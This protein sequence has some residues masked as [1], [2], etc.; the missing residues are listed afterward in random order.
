MYSFA[1]TIL[2][3]FVSPTAT[4]AENLDPF[5]QTSCLGATMSAEKA[6]EILGPNWEVNL[7]EG[8]PERIV[9]GWARYRQLMNGVKGKWYPAR[10]QP[11]PIR[12]FLYNSY[13][14]LGLKI[15]YGDFTKENSY[16]L[17]CKKEDGTDLFNCERASKDAPPLGTARYQAVLTDHC[18]R[19]FAS[20][21][22]SGSE[23]EWA[24]LHLF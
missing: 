11:D 8:N 15:Q 6:L 20:S 22:S 21:S 18:L 19:L 23:H 5:E 7:A 12:P 10:N 3:L 1:L 24:Y 9:K 14:R 4:Q 13:G 2:F 17:D 16:W